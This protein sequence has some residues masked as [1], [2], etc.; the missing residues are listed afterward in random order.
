MRE[1]KL[2]QGKKA[3][4]D[5]EDYELISKYKWV[6][7][8]EPK[9]SYALTSIIKNGVRTTM[10]M[11]RLI[12]KIFD[13]KIQIDHK[14]N[15]GLDNRKENLRICNR[16][17]NNMNTSLQKNNTTGYK[18]VV[19]RKNRYVAQT[20]WDKKHIYIGSFLTA[21]E[22]ARAY[23]KKVKE[24]HSEFAKLNFED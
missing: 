5:D 22:A 24:L 17:Q 23:D 21:E 8:K 15:N 19:R 11:H 7:A 12:M 9:V 18:G 3:L 1:I 13:P 10:R 20:Y 14:N 4:V 6:C 2:T 16:R